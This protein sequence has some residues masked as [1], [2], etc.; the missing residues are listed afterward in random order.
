[1]FSLSCFGLTF[2][3]SWRMGLAALVAFSMLMGLGVWQLKRSQDKQNLLRQ[4]EQMTSFLPIDWSGDA[5][6]PEPYRSVSVEGR[7]LPDVF[8]L[9]NQHHNHQFGYNILSPFLLKN[10]QVVLI[11]RGFLSADI[12]RQVLPDVRTP[13]DF[14]KV[15]GYTYYPSKK[16]LTLGVSFEKKTNQMTVIEILDLHLIGKI[17]H[18]SLYPFII[19][20]NRT[21]PDGYLREWPIVSMS[22]SRHIAYAIQW[23]AMA[24]VVVALFIGL[25]VKKN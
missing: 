20:L 16:Q 4:A 21:E 15:N 23:F 13:D 19:R 25:N 12:T 10:G 6:L 9:D 7:Y 24:I 11:D 5:V 1:M 2:T 18:K 3:F 22:P 17:L 14:R 8:F